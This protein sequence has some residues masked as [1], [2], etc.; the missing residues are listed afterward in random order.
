MVVLVWGLLILI[1]FDKIFCKWFKEV[2]D[3]GMIINIIVV[4]IK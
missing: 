4:I 2:M 1:F 3:C